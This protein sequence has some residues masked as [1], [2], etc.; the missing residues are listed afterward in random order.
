M[1][2]SQV[3]GI[4]KWLRKILNALR[5]PSDLALS[6][7]RK[8]YWNASQLRPTWREI[9]RRNSS[10]N[11]SPSRSRRNPVFVWR[12]N[13]NMASADLEPLAGPRRHEEFSWYPH[14]VFDN[15]PGIIYSL[16]WPL[17]MFSRWYLLL[18]VHLV[19]GAGVIM[20]VSTGF[21]FCF[22]MV[23]M[24]LVIGIL[25]EGTH[26]GRQKKSSDFFAHRI[27]D[28][29]VIS[30]LISRAIMFGFMVARSGPESG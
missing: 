9:H 25:E 3:C 14:R 16:L 27:T 2:A 17:L 11:Y 8:M 12:M 28:T 20:G 7:P 15:H 22:L 6:A 19:W 30:S 18:F 5:I 10:H 24:I 4:L 13:P 21:N 1:T 23:K 26:S 29:D